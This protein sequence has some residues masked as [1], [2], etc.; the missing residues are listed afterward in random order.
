MGKRSNSLTNHSTTVLFG[1]CLCSIP[2]AGAAVAEARRVLRPGGRV[3]LLEHVR[4]PA[5]LVGIAQRILDPL[6]VRLQ[7]DHLMREPL[8]LLRTQGFVIDDAQ[9]SPRG[10]VER[11][12]AYK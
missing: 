1:I 5:V 7:G 6:S 10:I 8:Q 11:A 12:V 4:S 9:R 3:V 2:D